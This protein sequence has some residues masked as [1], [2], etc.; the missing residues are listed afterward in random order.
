[1]IIVPA[2]DLL[3]FYGNK[4]LKA[5]SALNRFSEKNDF[6]PAVIMMAD[7]LSWTNNNRI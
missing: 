6:M 1:V 4:M 5:R 7:L 2:F 3:T